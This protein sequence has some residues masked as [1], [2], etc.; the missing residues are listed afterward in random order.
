MT[1]ISFP[2]LSEGQDSKY[3]EREIEDV[4]MKSEMEG[5]YVSS[6][7]RHT[8]RPRRTFKCGYTEISD[9]DRQKLEDFYD[10][11]RGGSVIF[12]WQDQSSNITYNVRFAE[13][14]SFKYAGIGKNKKWN[15]SLVLQEA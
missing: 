4:A 13:K 2:V 5:G 12:S 11:V 3:Y 14:I 8:R 9:A 6:R 10:L 7:A 15:V 1:D